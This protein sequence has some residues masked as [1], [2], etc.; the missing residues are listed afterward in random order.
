M[1][2]WGGIVSFSSAPRAHLI[3]EERSPLSGACWE[4]SCLLCC[5]WAQ[6]LFPGALGN[7]GAASPWGLSPSCGARAAQLWP[8]GPAAFT[9]H[10][11][12]EDSPLAP[13]SPGWL[14]P[15]PNPVLRLLN[16]PPYRL[17][18][19]EPP[20]TATVTI[21][22]QDK[23]KLKFRSGPCLAPHHVGGNFRVRVWSLVCSSTKPIPSSCF[24]F[25]LTVPEKKKNL[26]SLGFSHVRLSFL[27]CQGAKLLSPRSEIYFS[28]NF[29]SGSSHF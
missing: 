11:E 25:S 4:S 23:R 18:S 19:S 28:G 6:S 8:S 20:S 7:R 3:C 21:L 14:R 27:D 17:R 13:A 15:E 26:Y 9:L 29:F 1:D 22:S 12:P 5:F 2:K 24:L 10:W 16:A